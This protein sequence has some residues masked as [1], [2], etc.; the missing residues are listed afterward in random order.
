MRRDTFSQSMVNVVASLQ[1]GHCKNNRAHS[2]C[3]GVIRIGDCSN[4]VLFVAVPACLPEPSHLPDS[5]SLCLWA[6]SKDVEDPST[7]SL[8]SPEVQG[9]SHTPGE[10]HPINNGDWCV[11]APAPLL[12]EVLGGVGS[13][14]LQSPRGSEL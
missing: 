1:P 6:C 14:L 11:H 4:M 8:G 2:S 7:G 12:P 5:P 10:P 3:R 13:L 9:N